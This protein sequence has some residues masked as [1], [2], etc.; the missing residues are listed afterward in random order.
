MQKIDLNQKLECFSDHWSPRIIASL[1]G[2]EVKLAKFNSAFDWHS[3]TDADELF[4]VLEGSFIM[5][6][7]EHSVELSKGQMIVVPRGVEHRPVAE[8]ECSVLLVEPAGLLNTGDGEET[9]RT[10]SGTWI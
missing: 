5:E 1:N 10:T 9:E 8:A 4:L 7:R 3:H 2:Q 6:F